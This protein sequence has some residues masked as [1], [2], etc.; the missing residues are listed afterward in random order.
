MMSLDI[1]MEGKAG[2]GGVRGGG[3]RQRRSLF[4]P[5]SEHDLGKTAN[6]QNP[7]VRFR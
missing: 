1:K 5:R 4:K 6:L 7:K 2:A 3:R